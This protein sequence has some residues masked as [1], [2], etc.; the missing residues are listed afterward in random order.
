LCGQH[1]IWRP[2]TNGYVSSELGQRLVRL[3]KHWPSLTYS[4]WPLGDPGLYSG[5]LASAGIA[6]QGLCTS[7]ALAKKFEYGPDGSRWDEYSLNSGVHINRMIAKIRRKQ[8][9]SLDNQ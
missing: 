5:L 8:R 4:W 9:V 1:V 2:S 7:V 6:L 3:G